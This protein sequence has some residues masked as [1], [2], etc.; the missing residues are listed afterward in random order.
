MMLTTITW[1]RHQVVGGWLR[2]L[3]AFDAL[4]NT[5]QLQGK[6]RESVLSRSLHP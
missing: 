6:Q 4:A 2:P 3:A 1:V 5:G